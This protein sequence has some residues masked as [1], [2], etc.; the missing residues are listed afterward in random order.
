MKKKFL[1]LFLFVFLISCEKADDVYYNFTEDDLGWIYFSK[2]IADSQTYTLRYLINNTDT[3]SVDLYT[4]TD[5][6]SS[7]KISSKGL[8]SKYK[9]YYEYGQTVY[10]FSDHTCFLKDFRIDICKKKEGLYLGELYLCCGDYFSASL[11][12]DGNFIPQMVIDTATVNNKTYSEVYKFYPDDYGI[13]VVYFAKTYGF[14]KIDM[15]DGDKAELI[16]NH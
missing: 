9:E 2:K 7:E 10:Y 8:H 5:Y 15:Y 16:A 11:C 1:I 13:K 4:N 12:S 6:T 14:I 3:L